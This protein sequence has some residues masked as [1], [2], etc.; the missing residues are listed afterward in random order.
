MS[1]FLS[2]S[3][4]VG[5]ALAAL[6]AGPAAAAEP[7][8]LRGRVVK[9]DPAGNRVTIR[10]TA[11]TDVTLAVT[12]ESRLE[13]GG[14]P[15]ELARIK[16]GQRVRVEYTEKGGTKEVVRL[17]PA[18]VTDEDLGRE[19]R[20]ALAAAKE[21]TFQQKDK[22]AAELREVVADLDD[23]ID[24]LEARAKDAGATARVQIRARLEDLRQKRSTLDGRLAKV[25]S[26]TADAWEDVKA[27]VGAAAADLQKALKDLFKD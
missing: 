7:D 4:L 18:V 24:D 26:A 8:V 5:V 11:A 20:Q 12:P 6:L 22:Y 1:R 23:R 21:Y 3:Q 10:P 2:V 13:V 16:E 14:K 17:K 25:Q 9:V 27:G 19:V 15:A